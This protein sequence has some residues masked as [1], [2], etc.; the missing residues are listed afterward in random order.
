MPPIPFDKMTEAQRQAVAKAF[1][2]S[3]API[4]G[5][6]SAWLRSPEV[7]IGRK[8]VGDYLLGYHGAL[9]PKLTEIAILMTARQ[10]SQ[11]FIWNAHRELAEKA[12]VGRDIIQAIRE[13][14]RP[15]KMADDEAVIY[16][17]CDELHRNKSVSDATYT[18]AVATLG[19]QGLVE[20][21]AAI[22]H[23]ASNAMLANTVRL[24]LPAGAPAPLAP[25]PQ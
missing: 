25:F 2:G 8:M 21:V 4:G 7:L 22:G 1:P 12:G 11:P 17:F 3:R 10:W 24:P 23:W 15:A 5:P 19:E 18:R 13:G 14:R 16:D 9:S 20:A 6:Y